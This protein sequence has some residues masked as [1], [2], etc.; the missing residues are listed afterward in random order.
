MRHNKKRN[1]AFVF[2]S[3]LLEMTKSIVNNKPKR[4]DKIITIL[5]EYF[6]TE[7]VLKYELEAYRSIY[8]TKGVD[9][10]TAERILSEAQRVYF[11]LNPGHV[12]NTQTK[13]IKKVNKDLGKDV[14]NNFLPNY[15]TLA[16]I[17]QI[18]NFKTNPKS[19]VLL[20]TA[21]VEEM[22][23]NQEV[24]RVE[25]ID[26]IVFSTF[27]KKFNET[28]NTALNENQKDLIYKYIY[29]FSDNGLSLKMSLNEEIEKLKESISKCNTRDIVK[30]HGFSNRVNEV[31]TLL[32]S[33]KDIKD[34]E[35]V[36]LKVLQIQELCKE[37]E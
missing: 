11:S 23:K 24:N 9:K 27:V 6:H 15:K 16:S 14:F 10:R 29:S 37:L 1:T 26:N 4:K 22:I 36:L 32:E 3:L 30:K 25:P 33:F 21:V 8:E 17:S 20:E 5:K 12:F 35:K 34:D 28:Y 19:K 31:S 13:L 7:S 2:E 18:F